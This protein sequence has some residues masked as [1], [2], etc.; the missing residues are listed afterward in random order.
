MLKQQR[1]IETYNRAIN[2]TGLP[3]LRYSE[4]KHEKRV[5]DLVV[6]MKFLKC[7]SA[8]N[9]DKPISVIQINSSNA[10]NNDCENEVA[11]TSTLTQTQLIIASINIDC[12]SR[13]SNHQFNFRTIVLAKLNSQTQFVRR[14]FVDTSSLKIFFF[15]FCLTSRM[16]RLFA[17]CCN[18]VMPLIAHSLSQSND[19]LSLHPS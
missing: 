11:L 16:Q 8:F 3:R 1:G 19:G 18:P 10:R 14:Q 15:F 12:D 6:T 17:H 13:Q 7:L 5:P 9:S 4:E 2:A